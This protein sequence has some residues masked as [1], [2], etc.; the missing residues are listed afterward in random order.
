M[1]RSLYSY[2]ILMQQL[3]ENST[4]KLQ[5]GFTS[6]PNGYNAEPTG[7][8]NK[9]SCTNSGDCHDSTNDSLCDNTGTCPEDLTR[10]NNQGNNRANAGN[11]AAKYTNGYCPANDGCVP[12]V[13]DLHCTNGKECGSGSIVK[14][15]LGYSAAAK[16]IAACHNSGSCSTDTN[17]ST[18]MNTVQCGPSFSF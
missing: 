10:N 2:L 12:D 17:G 15:N 16:N 3:Q 4:G 7:S 6:I 8:H 9:E 13:N 1:N 11:N 18:C 14:N 5:G